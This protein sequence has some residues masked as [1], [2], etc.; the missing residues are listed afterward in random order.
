[1]IRELNRLVDAGLLKRDKRGN[2]S[3]FSADRACPVFE[4]VAGILRK[5]SG[6]ADVIAAALA[7]LSD[8]IADGFHLWIVRQRDCQ[9]R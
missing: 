5:T 8:R 9:G 7:L 4:E 3:L 2:Q 1:M 6:A